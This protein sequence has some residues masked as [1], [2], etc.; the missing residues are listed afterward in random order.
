MDYRRTQKIQEISKLGIG[1][2]TERHKFDWNQAKLDLEAEK[3]TKLINE[4]NKQQVSK[5]SLKLVEN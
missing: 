5:N 3:A 1:S 4:M 2:G